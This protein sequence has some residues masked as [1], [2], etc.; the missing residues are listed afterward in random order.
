[1]N[2]V[3]YLRDKIAIVGWSCRL[4]GATTVNQLWE[5]LLDG[6]CTVTEVPEDRFLKERFGHPRKQEKGKSYTWAAG[7]LDDL[8]G[9]D[10]TVFGISPREA[11]QLDP[12]QRLLLQMTWEALED[13]GIRPSSLVGSETG[14]FVGGSQSDYG[15]MFFADHAIADSQFATGTA[16][17]ILSNRISY[18]FDFRGPSLTVDTA[19]SSS[20]VALH[21]AMDALR[22]GRIDT[23]IVAGINAISSPAAFIAFS[24]A[25]MLSP[26]GRCHAF[27]DDAD[28]FVRAEGGVVLVLRNASQAKADL[29]PIHGFVHATDVNSD[30]RTNGISLPSI[31]AQEALLKRIYTRADVPS[32][33]LAFVEAHGTG[34]QAGDP[35]EATALGR[36]LGANRSTPLPIGSIKTNIGHLEP[37]SGLA[38]ILKAILALNHG[39]LP[40]SLHYRKP[41]PHIDFDDLRLRVCAEPLLLDVQHKLAGVNSFGFGGTNAHAIVE[42]GVS[43]RPIANSAVTKREGGLFFVSAETKAALRELAG[44]HASGVLQDSNRDVSNLASGIAYRRQHMSERI[45]VC[46]T[47]SNDVS[48]ALDDYTNAREN[49]LLVTGAVVA[50]DAPVA[51]VYSGNGSQFPGMGRAAY[52]KNRVFRE[53][54]DEVDRYFSALSGW[55][56]KEAMFG[57]DLEDRLGYTSVAQPLIFGIQYAATEALKASGL[58]PAVVLGHSIGEVAAATAA[59][60]LDLKTAVKVIF[61]RSKHQELVRFAGRMAVAVTPEENAAAIIADIEG[62]EI[63]AVNSPRAVTLA[64]TDEALQKFKQ[65]AAAKRIAMVE[66]DLDYPFHTKLLDAIQQPLVSDL[67]GIQPRD[68]TTPFMSTVTGVAMPGSRLNA[69]YWW[70]NIRK[71]VN[72]AGAVRAAAKLGAR[73][74]VE[75]GPSGTLTRHIENTLEAEPFSVAKLSVLEKQDSEVDPFVKAV[76]KALVFGARVELPTL[77]GENP[78]PGVLLPLYPWQQVPYRFAP[79][80]EAVGAQTDIHPLLGYRLNADMLEWRSQIDTERFPAFSDHKLADQ[81]IFPGM[82]YLEIAFAAATRWLKD[83]RFIIADCEILRPLDLSN[84]ETRELMTRISPGSSTIELFSRPRLSQAAWLLHTRSKIVRASA[85]A[86][87]RRFEIPAVTQSVPHEK[88]YEMGA[89]T[90]LNYG[91]EFSLVQ[92]AKLHGD[93]FISVSLLPSNAESSPY[94]AD[95]VRFDACLHGMLTTFPG[96]EAEQRGI[97]YVPIR[98]DEAELFKPGAV[99]D[100]AEMEIL[101]KS[102]RSM[103]ANFTIYDAHND[104]IATL[105][106]ARCHAIPLRRT[107]AILDTAV[108]ESM[109]YISG[110]LSGERGIGATPEDLLAS[111][112]ESGN[113]NAEPAQ[114]AALLVDGWATA[115]AYEIARAFAARNGS[116]DV[117]RLVES[118][119]LKPD[120]KQWLHNLLIQLEGARL[121]ENDA[122]VWKVLPDKSLPKSID[123]VS[124]LGEEHPRLAAEL[125]IA[126]AISRLP[127]DIKRRGTLGEARMITPA[128]TEFYDYASNATRAASETLGRALAKTMDKRPGKRTLR[129]LQLCDA[130]LAELIASGNTGIDLYLLEEAAGSLDRARRRL[131]PLANVTVLDA[132]SQSPAGTFD[133]IVSAHG[134]HRLPASVTLEGLRS[135]LAPGGV[136]AAIEPL[137]SLFKDIAF[138]FN[139]DWFAKSVEGFPIGALQ[140][141]EH[142]LN[143]LKRAGFD[144][145]CVEPIGYGDEVGSLLVATATAATETADAG[146]GRK[147]VLVAAGEKIAEHLAFD[148]ALEIVATGRDLSEYDL[149]A[150]DAVVFETAISSGS[151]NS[152]V[153]ADRCL[154]LKQCAE[155][156]ANAPATLWLIFSG[157][158][159]DDRHA[160]PIETA[161]WAFSRVLANEFQK[162]DVRRVDIAKGTDPEKAT[163]AL[164]KLIASTTEETE[165]QIDAAGV[166]VLRF[167]ELVNLPIKPSGPKLTGAKLVRQVRSQAR[168]AWQPARRGELG[169]DDVEIAVEATGLNFRDLMWVMGLLPDDMLE[170]GYTGPALGLECAGS[171]SRVGQNVKTVK[172][173]ERVLAMAPFAF[174]THAIVAAER[175]ARIPEGLSYEGAATIPVAFL[176]A[177]YGL[178]TLAKIKRNEWVLIHGA[179][180]G[181]GLAAIQVARNKGAKII[182]TAGSVAKRD[183][184]RSL[185]IVH[186]LDSRAVNITEDVRK[187]APQGVDVVLNS[188]AG[189]AMERSIA[190]LRPFGRFVELGKRDYVS[191]TH[192]GLRPFRRNLSYFGVDVDQLTGEHRELGEKVFRE[193][194]KQF[195][196]GV[197]KPLPHSVFAAADVA[198]AFELMQRSHHIGKIVVQPPKIQELKVTPQP[199]AISATGTHVITGAFGGFGLETAKWL[200]DRGARYLVMVG[201]RDVRTPE[202]QKVLAALKNAGAKVLTAACDVSDA[203]SVQKLFEKIDA[204]MP[205]VAGIIHSAMVLDDAIIPNL[206]FERF[207]SVLNPK[208]LG[209]DNLDAVTRDRKLEY[210]VMFSSVTTSMG[211]PGQGNYVAANAYMEGLARKR[212]ADGLP[213]LAIGWGP[214]LD[215]GVLARNEKLQQNLKK[216]MG[217]SGLRARE[218]LELMHH[219]LSYA[220][221]HPDAAVMTIS[222]N[223]GGFSSDLLPVLKS[224]TYARLTRGGRAAD[225]GAAQIDVKALLKAEG[226]DK[227]RVKISG[228]IVTHLAR[229]LHAPEEDISRTRPLAD[230]G[231]DSLM[232]LELV[233]GLE[234]TFGISIPLSASAGT[235]TVVGI[236]EAILSDAAGGEQEAGEEAGV[237]KF[238]ESHL[239]ATSAE[240]IAIAQKMVKDSSVR[241]AGSK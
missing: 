138:G 33:Q 125:L 191:N 111:A 28:G 36:A 150:P 240:K 202:V 32:D 156:M 10:P 129:V 241:S 16:L 115:A 135:L 70:Q 118:E 169:P 103:L 168:M 148:P 83:E 131:S 75:I 219:A 44:S 186:V 212:R 110:E 105:R 134:L 47:D 68:A 31:E 71:P 101:T 54:F 183:M 27:S 45:V 38:G 155:R 207:V 235:L 180:G 127:G 48:G 84:G 226:T 214:I 175:V 117:E 56:L 1:M 59:G 8:W 147:K 177:Y 136:F 211:N 167:Q 95:P 220:P 79:S 216:V 179:A 119:R 189:D 123:I 158:R 108:V 187:I 161:V 215:V 198:D 181:V 66:L 230:I 39:L 133:L 159:A 237:A 152:T 128:V 72:F 170:N 88:L 65:V 61:Y 46:S 224:P 50:N 213:A 58:R 184:L 157:A 171:V 193:V 104:V 7:V 178:V 35:I 145:A 122:G 223:D 140:S 24:Q 34:T 173:G 109:R 197:Y 225:G 192:I 26:T 141:A 49:S 37:A 6:R 96:L 222:P 55:S 77:F 239:T 218:G 15:Q 106:G 144:G 227:A 43:R 113:L 40:K 209:A 182:A 203:L 63:A 4:P 221:L 100:R 76:A 143:D 232:A 112:K 97:T 21:Q 14:V 208:V 205:P 69:N 78:G 236:A 94:L 165:F 41:S 64:G 162:L 124:S 87:P 20:L 126:G 151:S 120:H 185:G 200:A 2:S 174:S 166:R 73:C 81:T 172:P 93:R 12:Q 114:D 164:A 17:A 22:S 98:V 190:C 142:W 176:T 160:D 3:H 5:L 91:P 89:V 204:G 231:L 132:A 62:I 149:V 194:M 60:A 13:A 107:R 116:I 29:N 25:S 52:N 11:L 153:I 154:E 30:G 121:A 74:F 18:A 137:P 238:A 139:P 92:E 99:P 196:K 82:G 217:V 9:F 57:D 67:A 229:V 19:C 228:I 85:A 206:D 195:A 234:Q 163:A 51:F 53:C 102:E 199:F 23:A 188:L 90:G 210:F 233:S 42:G 80:V 130:P 201:R 86:A 146:S